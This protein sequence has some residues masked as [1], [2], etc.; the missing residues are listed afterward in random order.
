MA[1]TKT[2]GVEETNEFESLMPAREV[3]MGISEQAIQH[4]L[5][6]LTDMYPDPLE[7]TI[8]EVV[9]NAVDA[10]VKAG[11]DKPIEIAS[12]FL[13]NL[14][15]VRDYGVGMS[16]QE[17]EEI[18]CQYG[19]SDKRDD[20]RFIG[21]YGLGAKAPLSY[22]DHLSVK[23]V[24]NGKAVYFT[25][26][27]SSRGY[28]TNIDRV[29]DTSEDNGTIV[30]IPLKPEDVN[31]AVKFIEKYQ[32][33][34]FDAPISVDDSEK[35][36]CDDYLVAGEV[37]LAT[38]SDGNEVYGRVWFDPDQFFDINVNYKFWLAGWL[39]NNPTGHYFYSGAWESSKP[40]V[41]VELKPGVVDFVSSRDAI[42][43]NERVAEVNRNVLQF[44]EGPSLSDVWIEW[45]R[46][47]FNPN[48]AKN[49]RKLIRDL[50]GEVAHGRRIK[51]RSFFDEVLSNGL[52]MNQ[53]YLSD[54]KRNMSSRT[55]ALDSAS[56]TTTSSGPRISYSNAPDKTL[57]DQSSKDQLVLPRLTSS[58]NF[59]SLVMVTG[60][61]ESNVQRVRQSR[62]SFYLSKFHNSENVLFMFSES[63]KDFTD[64]EL[65]YIKGFFE[66]K[67]IE[68]DVADYV[69]TARKFRKANASKKKVESDFQLL[70]YDDTK[71]HPKWSSGFGTW[72]TSVDELVDENIDVVVYHN[73]SN[74][75][76]II[77]GAINNGHVINGDVASTP[78]MTKA[79]YRELEDNEIM[80][81][82]NHDSY[83]ALGSQY[84]KEALKDKQYSAGQINSVVRDKITLAELYAPF[85]AGV[86][87]IGFSSYKLE[88][89][90]QFGELLTDYLG[91][92]FLD[93]HNELLKEYAQIRQTYSHL[94]FDKSI[95]YEILREKDLDLYKA[96]MIFNDRNT[97]ERVGDFTR[98][99]FP[100]TWEAFKKELI[101][102][103]NKDIAKTVN[104]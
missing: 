69:E 79:L 81:I 89:S 53:M 5:S 1:L 3:K 45:M 51:D 32:Q 95:S 100:K 74:Y 41:L 72:F 99:K 26:T 8:R 44:L 75:E 87:Y 23:T 66:G 93:R 34:S 67:L 49:N 50:V 35:T 30:T 73:F 11:S 80:V 76:S 28:I 90:S 104:T 96:L 70:K 10:T 15:I 61:D 4:V 55:W 6:K 13:E 63:E 78:K 71:R 82:T 39:Y 12:P 103:V 85:S 97:L 19:E 60:V 36:V 33:F 92:D 22:T 83:N 7:A 20:F 86:G 68:V 98:E 46:S 101:D 37:L 57:T 58:F 31:R 16:L 14:L 77:Y 48:E 43:N 59:E 88:K 56:S 40:S 64:N 18:Y 25:M 47:T 38:D 52:T 2:N 65:A 17:V 42:T 91:D 62:R 54:Y 27:K 94:N 84:V 24:K 102:S 29:K 21:A 9:S